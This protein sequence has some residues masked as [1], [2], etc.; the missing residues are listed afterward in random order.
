MKDY[1]VATL[2]LPADDTW[3]IYY[4]GDGGR[5]EFMRTNIGSKDLGWVL[6]KLE[7]QQLEHYDKLIERI[8]EL[9]SKHE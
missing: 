4:F 9:E 3:M 1:K 5:G 6:G 2:A 8:K 7:E